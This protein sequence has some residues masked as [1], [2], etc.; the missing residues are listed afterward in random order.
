MRVLTH[1]RRMKRRYA[2]SASCVRNGHSWSD[3]YLLLFSDILVVAER[4]VPRT[5]S[6][7]GRSSPLP[8]TVLASGCTYT[9]P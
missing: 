7:G 1:K 5:V 6:T 8:G 2:S 9:S 3:R 4:V